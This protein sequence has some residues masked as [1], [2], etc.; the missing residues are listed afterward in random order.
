MKSQ[1]LN[2][3]RLFLCAVAGLLMALACQDVQAQRP[4]QYYPARPT[5]S[6][7]LL[8]KQVNLTGIPNYYSYVRPA[9]AFQDFVTRAPTVY[10]QAPRETL[11]N[12]QAV[13]RVIQQ[14]LRERTTTG[15]GAAAV[16]AVYGNYS[17]FYSTATP[18]R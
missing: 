16:P 11:I 7:Y 12:E 4:A 15:I 8:Y 17:H 5:F 6:P 10:R 3:G 1:R 2:G 9:T 13:A 14:E 18:G